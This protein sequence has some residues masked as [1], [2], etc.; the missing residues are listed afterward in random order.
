MISPGW[1][2]EFLFPNQSDILTNRYL[3]SLNDGG[4]NDETVRS[5]LSSVDDFI[6]NVRESAADQAS[7]GS[8]SNVADGVRHK[9]AAYW[10]SNLVRHFLDDS[11]KGTDTLAVIPNDI[12]RIIP[13][14]YAGSGNAQHGIIQK[15]YIYDVAGK[16][17]P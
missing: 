17:N 9:V 7:I 14:G 12:D 10:K 3:L 15:L 11:L 2:S 16:Y 13:G 8:G 5:Y 1:Y 6:L 4:S